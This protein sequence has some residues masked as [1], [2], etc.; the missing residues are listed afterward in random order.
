[1]S[2]KMFVVCVALAACGNRGTGTT[3]GSAARSGSGS[4]SGSSAGA[5]AALEIGKGPGHEAIHATL[6]T[7]HAKLLWCYEKALLQQPTPAGTIHVDVDIEA[8]GHVSLAKA[9]DGVPEV[10]ACAAEVI[11]NLEFPADAPVKITLSLGYT[12]APPR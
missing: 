9:T 7:Q 8:D 2:S 12:L 10:G 4:G 5:V 6:E 1:M 3:A 11:K